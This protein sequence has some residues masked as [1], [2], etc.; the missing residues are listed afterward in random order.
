M[1]SVLDAL[2]PRDIGRMASTCASLAK[3]C[4][5]E[6]AVW[7]RCWQRMWN[8]SAHLWDAEAWY[9]S[10]AAALS[11]QRRYHLP[12]THVE[13]DFST[14]AE[15]QPDDSAPR[16]ET[17]S[18]LMAT[19]AAEVVVGWTGG[20]FQVVGN[21]GTQSI[22]LP[23]GSIRHI[24]EHGGELFVASWAGVVHVVDLHTLVFAVVVAD[25][26]RPLHALQMTADL[27]LL[28]C[29]D[30][31]IVVFKVFHEAGTGAIQVR[32][33]QVL[34]GHVG[35]ITDM[36]LEKDFLATAG[37]DK[38]VRC[39]GLAAVPPTRYCWFSFRS[40]RTRTQSWCGV[41]CSRHN[42]PAVLVVVLYKLLCVC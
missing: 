42:T 4:V 8:L 18:C 29:G 34:S 6:G 27:L 36:H 11:F 13:D 33:L 32:K 9:G 35:A 16:H 15:A 17:V 39:V 30:G 1:L 14:E 23:G 40:T 10:Y 38:T 19:G 24:Q 28:S 12:P 37:V 7:R 5:Q 25:L 26:P 3:M 2:L 41:P 20:T 22:H 21:A 31:N